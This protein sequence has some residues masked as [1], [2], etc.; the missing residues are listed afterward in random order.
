LTTSVASASPSISSA[1]MSSGLPA[2]TT[3][4][5]RGCIGCSEESFFSWMRMALAELDEV[6]ASATR[7]PTDVQCPSCGEHYSNDITAHFKIAADGDT[8]TAVALNAQQE[9]RKIEIEIE[10]AQSNLTAVAEA[11][12]RVNAV[13]SARRHDIS[14]GDVVAAEGRNSATRVLRSRIDEADAKI[15]QLTARIDEMAA[16]MKKALDRRR[17]RTIKTFFEDGGGS[18][19]SPPRA[20]G[21]EGPR[22][23]AAYYYALLHTIREFGSAT[24]CP[25]V[26]DAPNQQGQDRQRLRA[27]IGFLVND[28]PADSQLILAVED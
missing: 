13:L 25:I 27:I 9:V 17:S 19:A 24:F 12:V 28:R 20:R 26:V 22:G 8:L 10:N 18:I 6:F 21:S 4:S 16:E 15:G 3:A 7:Q 14:P 1:M 5:R 2:C 23:L 11:I